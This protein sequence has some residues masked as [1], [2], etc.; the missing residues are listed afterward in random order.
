MPAEGHSGKRGALH[1]LRLPNGAGE[2]GLTTPAWPAAGLSLALVIY[3]LGWLAE[4]FQY[5]LDTTAIV[6]WAVACPLCL[7]VVAFGW[8]ATRPTWLL[9]LVGC[10]VQCLVHASV[11]AMVRGHL[12]DDHVGIAAMFAGANL[13]G[14]LAGRGLHLAFRHR[15]LRSQTA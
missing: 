7:A 8:Q 1:S 14:W 6:F 3:A 5:W 15:R 2:F 11:M 12:S 4:D 13:A 10:L 9:A